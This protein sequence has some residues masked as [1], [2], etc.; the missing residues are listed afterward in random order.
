MFPLILSFSV[1]LFGSIVVLGKMVLLGTM[2]SMWD[3]ST[4]IIF[5]REICLGSLSRTISVLFSGAS[6]EFDKGGVDD[7]IG[8]G[9]LD[10]FSL[11]VVSSPPMDI[12]SGDERDFLAA[13]RDLGAAL[14]ERREGLTKGGVPVLTQFGLTVKEI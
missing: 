14:P 13:L 11:D 12:A 1:S 7:L 9:D 6:T 8:D 2:V 10:P 3:L 4:L 5:S